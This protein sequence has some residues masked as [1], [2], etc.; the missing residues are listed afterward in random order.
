MTQEL[1]KGIFLI[2]P[3]ITQQDNQLLAIVND[4]AYDHHIEFIKIG[5]NSIKVFFNWPSMR[6]TKN[7]WLYLFPSLYRFIQLSG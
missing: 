3:Y 2:N 5:V 4:N 7:P 1:A 6:D